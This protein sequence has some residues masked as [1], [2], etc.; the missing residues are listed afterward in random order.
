MPASTK[1]SLPDPHLWITV[2]AGGVG[3]RFWPVSTPT[4][5]KQL[6]PLASEQPLIS[7]TIARVLALVPR[8]H[9]RILTGEHLAQPILSVVP[10]LSASEVM[11]EPKARG[12]GPVLAW[13][14]AELYRRDP[15]AIM[16]SL[17]SDHVIEPDTA[18]RDE[19]LAAAECAATHQRLVCIGITPTRPETGYGY[20]KPGARLDTRFDAYE[21]QQFV[22]KPDPELATQYVQRGY[23][24]NSGIF[25]WPVKLFLNEIRK[26][27]REIAPH[28]EFAIEGST[29]A[30]F[31]GVGNISVDQAVL[32]RSDRVAV[33]PATCRRDDVGT[34]DAVGR[35]RAQDATG[36]VAVGAVELVDT[37]NTIAWSEHGSIVTFG[38]EDLV[39]VRT[40]DVTF[41]ARRDR[42]AELK[43][44]LDRIPQNVR[45]VNG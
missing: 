37:A 44:L 32:E 15:D 25:V 16:A 3:S 45:E 12:T 39:I 21:V 30:Y 31:D 43:Q 13:A 18:L 35:T 26:H 8:D 33:L 38:I 14:A 4:R 34:W 6:L 24:W 10:E 19:I 42:T 9:I 22:E 40:A 11:V 1:S 27:A 41:V 23:V 7:D 28:L 2:L 5:P 17:H 29:N 36:N 20:I